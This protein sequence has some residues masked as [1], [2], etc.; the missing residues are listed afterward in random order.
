MNVLCFALLAEYFGGSLLHPSSEIQPIKKKERD[1]FVFFLN[2]NGDWFDSFS[3]TH[4]LMIPFLAICVI[5]LIT[6]GGYSPVAS[7]A[8]NV[9]RLSAY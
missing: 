8:G 5:Q 1:F 4:I 9:L 3:A 2:K 7:I 6:Y